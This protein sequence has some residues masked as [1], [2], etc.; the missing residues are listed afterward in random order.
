VRQFATITDVVASISVIVTWA[1]VRYGPNGRLVTLNFLR[2]AELLW[3][4]ELLSSL[5]GEPTPLKRQLI[6]FVFVILLLVEIWAG[7]FYLIEA[8]DNTQ[9]LSFIDSIYFIVVSLG[10]VGYGDITAQSQL[11]RALV[12]VIISVGLIVIPAEIRC[13]LCLT[14]TDV[15]D[16]HSSVT[17]TWFARSPFVQLKYDRSFGSHVIL[18][19]T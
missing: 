19:G 15:R 6:R 4:N 11:G 8:G 12:I 1:G 5:G 10:T 7:I 18:A 3:S 13:V 2:I 14:A 17:T 16:M 9:H